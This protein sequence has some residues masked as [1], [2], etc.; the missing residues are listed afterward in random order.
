[1]P[2]RAQAGDQPSGATGLFDANGVATYLGVA[3][4]TV[5]DLVLRGELACYRI[6]RG[7]RFTT[8]QIEE[9][10]ARHLEQAYVER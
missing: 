1:M 4:K 7:M 9:Y 3:R 2:A 10:L 8:T 5:Y 6:G